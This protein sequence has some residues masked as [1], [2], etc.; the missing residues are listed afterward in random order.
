M[1]DTTNESVVK[2]SWRSPTATR[3]PS[4]KGANAGLEK[5]STNTDSISR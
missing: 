1:G 2:A 4:F 5:A 3:A